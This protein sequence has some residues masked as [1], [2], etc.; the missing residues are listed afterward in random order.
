M[1]RRVFAC[2]IF[3]FLSA[4]AGL[5]A[6]DWPCF[7]GPNRD[8]IST[9]TGWT[10][11]WPDGKPKE[12][13]RV[14]VGIG[15][16]TVSVAGDRVYTMGN[17]D[18]TD[19]VW[20]LDAK[21]GKTVWT[22]KY[23]CREGSYPGPRMTPTIDGNVIYTLGR[24]G[25]LYCLNEKDGKPIWFVDIQKEYGVKQS[26]ARWGLACSPLVLGNLLIIDAGR[27]LALLKKTGK[28][29]WASGQ[30]VAGFSSPTLTRIGGK[31]FINCFNAHG[32]V[33]VNAADGKELGRLQWKT[34]YD[35]N[36]A[37]PIPSGDKVFISSGYGKGCALVQVA[38]RGLKTVYENEEMRNHCNSCVLYD[39]WIYGFDG[40][41]GSTGR[42]ACLDFATGKVKWAQGGLKVG[43]LMIADGKIIAMLDGGD[44]LIAEASPDGYEELARAKVLSGQCWTH[45][46]LCGGRIYCRS[47]KGSELVC[48]DVGGK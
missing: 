32:L 6:A 28:L 47:N 9:E 18:D 34:S 12:L 45:P 35:V 46:V 20:C 16:S 19:I 48:L 42:L 39:G 15:F 44:L 1:T 4:G 37:S 43:S 17:V 8:L 40:Q 30:D 23:P 38:P 25:Q 21:T 3:G 22:H 7:H 31:T 10:W 11:Q 13:W 5:P 26:R 14:S 2:A 29:A 27:T 33:L 41:Q 36:S 24:D